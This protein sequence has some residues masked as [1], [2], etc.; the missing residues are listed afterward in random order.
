MQDET[1]SGM[2]CVEFESFL[3][4]ALDATL[5]GTTLAAFEAHQRTC[6]A[7]AALYEQAAAGM[8]WL[9]GLEDI[10]PPKNLVHNIL[11]QT[12][13]SVPEASTQTAPAGESWLE[14]LKVRIAPVFAPV[15]TPRFAMSFGMAFF[16]I[17]M[18]ANILGVHASDLKHLDL[19]PKGL[20]RTYYSTE[21]RVV[22]YYENIRLVYEIESRVRD[23][24]RA[25]TPEK[26][27]ENTP[28]S[29]DKKSGSQEQDRKYQNYSRDVSQPV[30]ARC[31]AVE[32]HE[33]PQARLNRRTV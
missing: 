24:R 16:S 29:P 17:T 6:P 12:I 14:R 32:E 8:H 4:E 18:L 27:E 25:A 2:Q 13:G 22:R 28:K 1:K 33:I 15:M 20:Q 23:L 19:S 31:P 9:K 10:D 3:T 5:H 26:Q 11:A 30:L 21:A 7:C